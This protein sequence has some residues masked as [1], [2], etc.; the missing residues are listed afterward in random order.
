M[1]QLNRRYCCRINLSVITSEKRLRGKN[2]RNYSRVQPE[3]HPK[4]GFYLVVEEEKLSP[5]SLNKIRA[6]DEDTAKL[7]KK[8]VSDSR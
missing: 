8:R 1:S 4:K 3:I 7:N 6:T 5:M 2:Q